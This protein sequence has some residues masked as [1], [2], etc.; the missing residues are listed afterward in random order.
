[1]TTD[2]PAERASYGSFMLHAHTDR[3]VGSD[4][5]AMVL[6]FRP[7]DIVLTATMLSTHVHADDR[8][9]WQA[10]LQRCLDTGQ[11]TVVDHRLLTVDRGQRAATTTLTAQ[12]RD[13]S[14]ESVTGVVTDLSERV[15]AASDVEIGEAVRASAVTRSGI[16]QAKGIIMAAFDLDAEQAFALLRWHSSHSNRK[17]RDLSETLI[18]RLAAADPEIALRQRL[19]DIFTA[20]GSPARPV[21]G[22]TRA[23]VEP[24][25]ATASLIPQALL[26]GILT[27]AAQEASVAITVADVI[28]ADQP[29]VYANPAFERLTGYGTS[30]IIGRNCRF[31]Q[32]G[33]HDPQERAAIR[34]AID[35]GRAVDTLILNFRRD[36]RPFWNEFHLSP[37]RNPAGRLTHYIGYQLDVTDRIERDQQL[38]R[39]AS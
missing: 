31:L 10:G 13:R 12:C 34:Q 27:R 8:V 14:V 35:Q 30:D 4:E 23:A 21:A 7:G 28:A 39:L 22:R 38:E 33:Q 16:D 9:R 2:R 17:L 32:G 36:G 29:L 1:M 18:D 5:L 6:G 25:L 20:L 37:V 19:A 24:D 26:P 3:F 15:K 11:P